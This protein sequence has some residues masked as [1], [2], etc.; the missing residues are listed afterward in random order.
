MPLISPLMQVPLQFIN[1]QDYILLSNTI[2]ID[3]VPSLTQ[4]ANNSP[5]NVYHAS[6]ILS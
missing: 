1:P 3:S 5:P 6:Y 4:E 2:N